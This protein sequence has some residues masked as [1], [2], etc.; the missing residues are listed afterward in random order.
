MSEVKGNRPIHLLQSERREVLANG[1]RRVSGLEGIHDGVQ[2]DTRAG[3]VESAVA[4]RNSDSE[5]D[6]IQASQAESAAVAA[7]APNR[8]SITSPRPGIS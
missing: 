3:D 4:R 2:G 1:F 5:S 6:P 8:E 7:A